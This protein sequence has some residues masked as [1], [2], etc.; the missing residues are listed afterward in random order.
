MGGLTEFDIYGIQDVKVKGIPSH[1]LRSPLLPGH[2]WLEAFSFKHP[3]LDS[4][5]Q[6]K[7]RRDK[8]RRS[9]E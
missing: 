4:G 2:H 8:L 6:L 3:E 9:D 1:L 5:S 7:T